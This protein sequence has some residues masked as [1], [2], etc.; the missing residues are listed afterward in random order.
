MPEPKTI[1]CPFCQDGDILTSY[2]RPMKITKSCRGSATTSSKSYF[3]KEKWTIITDC[4]N[5]GKSKSEIEKRLKGEES[6]PISEAVKRAKESG[7][8][9]KF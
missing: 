9:L 2:T 7:L 5:C 1:K 8:P 6:V 4:S 3:S